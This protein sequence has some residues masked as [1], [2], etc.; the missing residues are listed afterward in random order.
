[1]PLEGPGGP[2]PQGL[3]VQNG[4]SALSPAVREF[5]CCSDDSAAAAAAAAGEA[6]YLIDEHDVERA[7]QQVR[8]V[9]WAVTWSFSSIA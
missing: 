8:A 9:H 2:L 7:M 1:M 6:F 3:L 4:A 5:L